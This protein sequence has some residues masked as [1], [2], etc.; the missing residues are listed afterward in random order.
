[1]FVSSLGEARFLALTR[2]LFETFAARGEFRFLNNQNRKT[3]FN[4]ELKPTALANQSIPFQS[5]TGPTRVHR[6]AEDLEKFRTNHLLSLHVNRSAP[7]GA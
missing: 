5:Q 1:M 3:V 2:K 7:R 6:T 4:L